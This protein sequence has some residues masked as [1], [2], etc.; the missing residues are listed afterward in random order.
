MLDPVDLA[1]N[2]FLFSPHYELDPF[3]SPKNVAVI[4]AT[5][6]EGSVGR[7]LLWNLLRTPFG[8]TVFPV[9]PRRSSVLGIKAYPNIK[10]VPEV[11]DLAVIV[12]PAH[13]VPKIIEECIEAKVQ[14]A[15]II[16][17]GFKEMGAPG[18]ALEEEIKAHINHGKIRIVGPNCLGVMNPIT[19]LNA[20]FASDMALKGNIAFISQS[21]ALCTAVLDWSLQEKVGFSAF[22]SV[23]SMIDVNWGDFISYFGNDPHTQSILIY[24]ESISDPRSFLS[25]AR[26]VSL[27]KPIILIK[28]GVTAES[29]HAA[30]SHTGAL[31]GSNDVLDAALNRVGVLRVDT[32]EELFSMAEILSKQPRPT[33]PNLTIITN[34][35]GPGVIATDALIE[36]GGKLTQLSQESF[37]R[38]NEFLPKEWSHN[39]PVDILGD[40]TDERYKKAVEIVSKDPNTHGI[41]VIL[42]PQYMTDPVAIGKVLTPFAHLENR[43]ILA[44]WMGGE[45]VRKGN[46]IL[47]EANI[48]AFSYP[49]SA[50]IA[51]AYMWEYSYNLQGIYETPSVEVE[52]EEELIGQKKN[53]TVTDIINQARKEKRNLLTEFESKEILK[54]Y[55]IP[56]VETIIARSEDEAVQ[57]AQ[58]MGFPVVVKLYSTSVTHKTDVGGVKLNLTN[59]QD[60]R[61]AYVEIQKS[62]EK[63]TGKIFEGVTVQPMISVKGYEVILGSSVD[64][65]FGPTLLFGSGGQLVEVFQD[66][67]LALPPLTATLAERM[68][69]R[70]KIYKALK[71]V[72]GQ[73][74]A[75][76]EELKKILIK[77]S[78]L[79]AEYPIIAECDINPLLVGPDGI[80]A[81]DARIVLLE[82]GKKI[83]K[84]A[85]RPYP[86]RYLHTFKLDE[87]TSVMIRP[88]RPEDE[89]M[90]KKFY[91][92]LSKKTLMQRFFKEWKFDELVAHDR[93]SKICYTDYDREIALVVEYK[94]SVKNKEF[95]AAARLAKMAGGKK[96][97]FAL[98]VKDK[99]QH[100]GLGRELLQNLIT[101]AKD[102]KLEKLIAQMLPEN[103]A[104]QNLC[105]NAGFHLHEDKSTSLIIAEL[106]LN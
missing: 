5:E 23:G 43:P 66:R 84:L 35:G 18:I 71:G 73:K 29:A 76:I 90:I 14:T 9:N 55:N 59:E 44:S 70:T 89:T 101:I 49:D 103:N 28:A 21:G 11:V 13:T 33:G 65:D 31:A 88:I 93:L 24:M 77:F 48:P 16:S 62:Y 37:D 78:Y 4:G 58:K 85:I 86:K 17:A 69:K 95:L 64:S 19:G 51:F 100:K 104:M 27:K 97:A 40:A 41:L 106:D 12:T 56:V 32:I 72:R 36:N 34:A 87:K 47:T 91:Q 102:E 26:E 38:L 15:I 98:I 46:A 81:L 30:A 3:F 7:T 96:G 39:N 83:P 99:W 22:V 105:K 80:I 92:D 82:E 57:I 25:A 61:E 1:M 2:M 94:S 53:K 74:S 54:A 20:T 79:I 67:A 75:D 50:C 8:G 60:I 42:T 6:K 10:E 68:M 45:T 63:I 52:I